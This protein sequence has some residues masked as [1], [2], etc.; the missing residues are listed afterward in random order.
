[1]IDNDINKYDA[2]YANDDNNDNDDNDDSDDND[3]NDDNDDD[4]H[5]NYDNDENDDKH[6]NYDNDDNGTWKSIS[7][8]SSI[9]R[10]HSFSSSEQLNTVSENPYT[11]LIKKNQH[12]KTFKMPVSR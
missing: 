8:I 3:D 10:T 7:G 6:D 9:V 5:D 1:M 2:N 4:K 11:I 12:K